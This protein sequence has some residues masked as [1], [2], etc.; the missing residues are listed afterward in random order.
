MFVIALFEI[1]T[2]HGWPAV[3]NMSNSS[4]HRILGMNVIY[5][6]Y[7]GGL[8]GFLPT[9]TLLIMLFVVF[10]IGGFAGVIYFAAGYIALILVLMPIYFLGSSSSDSYRLSCFVDFPEV[11]QNRV[12]DM[13]WASRNYMVHLKVTN[14]G[15][16]VLLSIVMIGCTIYSVGH[17]VSLFHHGLGAIGLI[18]GAGLAF[19]LKGL[20][21][22]AVINLAKT[23]DVSKGG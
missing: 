16:A 23:Y 8:A 5:A 7:L 3:Q 11:L 21:T 10:T 20:N 9:F 6:N 22:C 1:Y 2:S 12:Y 19:L 18:L 17:A 13:A 14:A 4:V 15:G